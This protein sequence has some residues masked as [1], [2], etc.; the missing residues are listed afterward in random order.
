MSTLLAV[1]ALLSQAAELH[2]GGIATFYRGTSQEARRLHR[3][4]KYAEAKALWLSIERE[5]AG[6]VRVLYDLAC[7]E[8]RLGDTESALAHLERVARMGVSFDAERDEDL[9]SLAKEPRFASVVAA[10]ASNGTLRTQSRELLRVDEQDLLAESL[11]WD[12]KTDALFVGSVRKRKILRIASD[13]KISDFVASERDG[14]LGVVGLAI[15]ASA[16]RLYASTMGLPDLTGLQRCAVFAFDLDT[17]ATVQHVRVATKQCGE[18]ALLGDGSLVMSANQSGALYTWKPG[19]DELTRVLAPGRL[20]S[21]QGLVAW[22]GTR[23]LTIADWTLGLFRVDL[24][25]HRVERVETPS[26]VCVVGLDGLAR[27]GE[28][29]FAV[30]NGV[31]PHCLL[32]L[33]F[34]PEHRRV[35]RADVVDAALSSYDE[36]TSG[37]VRAKDFV[38]VAN[39]HWPSYRDDGTPIEGADRSGPI[40][41]AVPRG[42]AR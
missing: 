24:D 35:V 41:L 32:S 6:H 33:V 5:Y 21:P 10:F 25:T 15:D 42:E 30:R 9:V 37:A 40:L 12:P 16:R 20:S 2:V 31:R 18:L 23:V 13:G 19:A 11:A 26:D 22:P 34:D 7:A 39:S 17:G 27:D 1:F 8:A 36:P 29:V 3:D 14:L 38:Y 4:G 28:R